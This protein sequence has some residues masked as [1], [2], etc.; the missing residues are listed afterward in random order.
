MEAAEAT[1]QPEL[2][3]IIAVMDIEQLVASLQHMAL[4]W[5]TLQ[6]DTTAP[7]PSGRYLNDSHQQQP[8]T[9]TH[10][11]AITTLTPRARRYMARDRAV[12]PPPSVEVGTLELKRE[13]TTPAAV[14]QPPTIAAE[15]S[16]LKNMDEPRKKPAAKLER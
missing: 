5:K 3:G 2:D 8:T 9:D 15:M 7:V 16:T 1:S 14:Q 10:P 12:T 13:S 11:A 4:Q 6:G